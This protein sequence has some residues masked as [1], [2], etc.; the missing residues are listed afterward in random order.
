MYMQVVDSVA[1]Y[2]SWRFLKVQDILIDSI[3]YL[4]QKNWNCKM[5]SEEKPQ[6][7]TCATACHVAIILTRLDLFFSGKLLLMILLIIPELMIVVFTFTIKSDS[8][9]EINIGKP[10]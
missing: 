2:V 5:F 10:D 3:V 4:S 6:F 8:F 7:S 9:E 1:L